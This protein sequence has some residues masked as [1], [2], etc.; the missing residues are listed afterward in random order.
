[1]IPRDD[2]DVLAVDPPA[3]ARDVFVATPMSKVTIVEQTIVH[4]NHCVDIVDHNIV[5]LL[6]VPSAFIRRI[7][8]TFGHGHTKIGICFIYE[9]TLTEL[10][11]VPMTKMSISCEEV[12]YFNPLPGWAN[13]L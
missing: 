3:V 2:E 11:D 10:D 4:T 6:D 1:M 5:M 7:K 8:L 12:H 9:G 13:S